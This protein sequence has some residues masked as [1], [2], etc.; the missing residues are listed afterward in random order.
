MNVRASLLSVVL[1]AAVPA[2]CTAHQQQQTQNQ[3]ERAESEAESAAH[4]AYL[5]SSVEAGLV[6]VDVDAAAAVHVWVHRGVATLSG[7][8]HSDAER[9]RY[10]RAAQ[11]VRGIT[12]VRDQLSI[13]PNLRGI[14]Q[15]TRDVALDARVSA[16]IAAEAGTNVFHVRPTSNSGVVTLRGTVPTRSVQQ[17]IVETTSRVPGV[18][19]VIDQTVV[20]GSL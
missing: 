10:V 2:A 16:A 19:R 4:Q 13:N 14:R 15:D 7:Q 9:D 1:L 11:S 17:T 8:A 20:E 3:A 5:V 6:G 12:S 18:E